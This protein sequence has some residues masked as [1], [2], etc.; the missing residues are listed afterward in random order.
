VI[1]EKA[2]DLNRS[3]LLIIL[4][5]SIGDVVR[6]IPVANRLKRQWPGIRLG[7]SVETPSADLLAGHPAIDDLIIFP[8]TDGPKGIVGYLRTLRGRQFD[9]V[10]DLQRH[11]KSGLISWLTR[12]PLRLGFSQADAKEG[13][14]LF[15]NRYISERREGQS[16]LS[17]YLEFAEALGAPETPL[18]WEFAL[19]RE[20]EER[21]ESLLRE[22]CAPFATFFVG[23]SW[24]SKLWTA[25]ATAALAEIV[26]KRWRIDV[27]L[28]GDKSDV[29]F[30]REVE[31]FSSI[32]VKD[33]TGRTSLRDLV[34]ILSRSVFC[35][36]PDTGSMHLSAALGI[37]VVSLFAPSDPQWSS[38]FGCE[39]LVVRSPIEC[40][41]CMKRVCRRATPC[42]AAIRVEEVVTKIETALARRVGHSS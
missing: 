33:L 5:G 8:R 16:K 35:V 32:R 7:W 10:I 15:N 6:A 22:A 42:M 2:W 21:V 34:G 29:A 40:G 27:V 1:F 9:I 38:P 37:P 39:D 12:A 4:H 20:D 19:A 17:M 18:A 3:R 23:A 41:P 31:R 14:W 30:A 13:N 24:P 11:L 28:V 26:H 36:G 25:R